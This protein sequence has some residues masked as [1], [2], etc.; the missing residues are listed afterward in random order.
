MQKG[1]SSSFSSRFFTIHLFHYHFLTFSTRFVLIPGVE[2][3]IETT[4][5]LLRHRIQVSNMALK[6]TTDPVGSLKSALE[7][8][9]E[10]S[11]DKECKL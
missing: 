4:S 8:Y 1:S 3:G 5:A 2:E 11:M 6:A 7:R 10:N 9:R